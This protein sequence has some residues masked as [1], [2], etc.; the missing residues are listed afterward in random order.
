MNIESYSD[1]P[2]VKLLDDDEVNI[3]LLDRKTPASTILRP[4]LSQHDA[5]IVDYYQAIDLDILF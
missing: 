4:V 1:L 5:H 3:C 2:L